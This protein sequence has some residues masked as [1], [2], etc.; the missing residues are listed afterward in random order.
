MMSQSSF[1]DFLATAYDMY[2]TFLRMGHDDSIDTNLT[3]ALSWMEAVCKSAVSF[4]FV[5]FISI[6]ADAY[7][8][9]LRI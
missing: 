5:T 7:H 4:Y 2:R 1:M 9:S 6:Y 3:P 8:C